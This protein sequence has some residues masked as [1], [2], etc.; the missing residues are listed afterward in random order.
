M[1]VVTKMEN[2]FT[3]HYTLSLIITAIAIHTFLHFLHISVALTMIM[4]M[5]MVDVVITTVIVMTKLGG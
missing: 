5:K 2:N 4:M 3:S 1:V